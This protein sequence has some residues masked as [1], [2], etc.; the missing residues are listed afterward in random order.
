MALWTA[1]TKDLPYSSMKI[2]SLEKLPERSLKDCCCTFKSYFD[3]A[4]D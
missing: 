3:L 4:G 2:T 1:V